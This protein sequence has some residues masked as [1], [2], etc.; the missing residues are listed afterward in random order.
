MGDNVINSSESQEPPTQ[1]LV[2]LPA[3]GHHGRPLDRQRLPSKARA[4][5]IDKTGR[6][7]RC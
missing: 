7:Q 5:E 4:T 2:E 1:Q 6:Q 3:V